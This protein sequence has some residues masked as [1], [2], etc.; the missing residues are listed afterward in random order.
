[1]QLSTY[2]TVPRDFVGWG[3]GVDV[4]V[5]VHI[6]PFLHDSGH[7]APQLHRGYWRVCGVKAE[8][9]ADVWVVE[10]VVKRHAGCGKSS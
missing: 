9:L 10:C 3:V 7:P 1:M 8:R 6:F 5:E 2:V 4:T